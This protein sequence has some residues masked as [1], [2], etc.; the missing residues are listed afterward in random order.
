LNFF[1][2]ADKFIE[3]GVFG[4]PHGVKGAVRLFLHNTDSSFLLSVKTIYIQKSQDLK[5]I[6]YSVLNIQ[7]GSKFLILTL[8]NVRYKDEAELLK[9][10]KLLL[11]RDSLPSV[12]EDEFYIADLIGMNVFCKGALIGQI[13]SSRP[14][15]EIEVIN[16][17][18]EDSEV[19]IPLVDLFVE[20]LNIKAG[21][22][23]VKDIDDLPRNKFTEKRG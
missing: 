5:P 3:I 10:S 9:G 11:L 16:V 23:V 19:E 17:K 1:A 13:E 12:D 14:Q 2:D 7:Q 8:K 15:G 20:D 22:L 21:K 6:P 18:G 4:R